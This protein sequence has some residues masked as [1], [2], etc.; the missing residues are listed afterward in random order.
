MA[1]TLASGRTAARGLA[2]VVVVASCFRA[3]AANE[4][5]SGVSV[6]V[7]GKGFVVVAA[8]DT[9]RR[10]LVSFRSARDGVPLVD[11]ALLLACV[12][13]RGESDRF[14]ALLRENLAAY[15]HL[16][17]AAAA[18]RA[19]A[20]FARR[21]LADRRRR[22]GGLPQ[23]RVLLGSR[24]DDGAARVHWIDETGAAAELPYAAHGVGAALVLGHLDGAYDADMSRD[25]AV[26][27]VAACLDVLRRRYALNLDAATIKVLDGA[28]CETI[29]W[30][31]PPA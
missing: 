5:F 1:P 23:L 3:A 15:A 18:P 28:G 21:E 13:D 30:A 27:L 20:H 12:G 26:D 31:P 17:G 25:A 4:G 16:A 29:P 9:H 8:D 2:A 6:G 14:A 22:G 11:D 24:G 10:G 19:A 7:A